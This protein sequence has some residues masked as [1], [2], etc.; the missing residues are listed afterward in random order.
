M[1]VEGNQDKSKRL[2]NMSI[3]TMRWAWAWVF[4]LVFVVP[5][6][7]QPLETVRGWITDAETGETLPG[8]NVYLE[9]TGRG[10]ASGLDG[11]IE[12]LDVQPGTYTL[13]ARLIG[14]ETAR[15]RITVAAGGLA[16]VKVELK[17]QPIDLGEVLA[18]ADRAYAA[19]SSQSVRA[20]DLITRPARSAQDLL[21]LTPGLVTAQHAGGGKAEQVFLRGFD[22][23]HGTDVA[24]S[25]DGMPVNMVS[26]GHGQGYA[27]LHF[28]IPDVVERVDV[29]KGPY[30]AQFGNLATAGAVAL[31]TRDRLD[32]NLVRLEGGAFNTIG[33][34]TLYQVPLTGR[35]RGAYLAGQF[36][37]TDGPFESPQNFQRFNLFGKFHVHL[38]EHAA[39]AVSVG[40]F[41][42]A[43]DA[44]GQ[45]PQRAI[46][47][48]R[49]G[50]FG[51]IDDL[52]G[53]KTARHNVTLRYEA[54]QGRRR[55]RLQGYASRYTFKLFSNF[56]FFLEDPANGD[57]I[58][59]TDDR[60]LFGL[61]G[62]YRFI[63]D[64]GSGLATTTLGGGFR[65]DDIEV[66]LWQS[67]NRL[68]REGLVDAGLAEHNLYLW[69]EQEFVLS[70]Q[71][72]LQLGVRGDYLAYDVNDRLEGRSTRLPHASGYAQQAILS[73]K[74]SLVVSP[75]P[76]FDLFANVGTGFHSNDARNVVIGRRIDDLATAYQRQGLRRDEIDSRLEA[77]H[78]D[79]AQRSR[80]ALPR[81]V[82]GELGFRT[83]LVQ[84]L[85]V[86]AAAWWLDL[87]R[88]F[89]YVGDGGVTEPRGRTRRYGLDLEAR[90]GLSAW[91]SADADLNLSRGFFRDEPADA[92]MIPLAPRI[93][94]TG[95]LM[96]LHP[97]GF[98]GRLRT[99][100]VGSRPAN[101]AGSV[102]AEGYTVFTL[103]A[104]YRR[105]RAKVHLV[106]ENLFDVAWNEAQFETESRLPGEAAPIS[107]LHFTPGNPRNVRIGV[108]Y[109]F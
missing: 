5:G 23:D 101:E 18:Q 58:E 46:A 79:P 27:D 12:I 61:N 68:R 11:R 52:E 32:H 45:I 41:S 87:D 51:A 34:T 80:E 48:G 57:M 66:A 63:Y 22:A 90:L 2:N 83:R 88:E 85:S 36:Y 44:S 102:I 105:G 4:L 3:N 10:D 24:I 104:A 53:G 56:T 9:E 64:L 99:V 89:V 62:R 97:K 100:Y 78:F 25:V 6:M 109:L 94:A 81:A 14:Y 1:F 42:A 82:G 50:R 16:E 77:Q 76:T 47:S 106:L 60:H 28:V 67:P 65:T 91:L 38:S 71:I 108:S 69:A 107:E 98:E 74:A 103:N 96:A 13:V 20:F 26:H 35:R 75:T 72:R 33:L 37:G 29:F 30:E 8:V 95:G 7:A 55:F 17:P 70:S 86:A 40:G 93:T 39:L 49:I 59:Q 84:T 31:Q 92:D 54:G 15:Q 43:W 21:R 19:A 73:P